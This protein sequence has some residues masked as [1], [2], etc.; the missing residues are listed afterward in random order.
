[1]AYTRFYI[2]STTGKY[3]ETTN[4]WE[5]APHEKTTDTFTKEEEMDK[6]SESVQCMIED[7][8]MYEDSEC[9]AKKYDE[10]FEKAKDYYMHIQN[11]AI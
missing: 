4:S 3:E 7:F 8:V 5:L 6:R 11:M 9:R 2:S 10:N 1:M